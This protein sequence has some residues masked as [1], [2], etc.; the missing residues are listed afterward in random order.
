VA[1]NPVSMAFGS[2]PFTM[3][4]Y[5][6]ERLGYELQYSIIRNP[7]FTSDDNVKINEVYDRGFSLALRQKFYNPDRRFG[8]FYFAQELRFSTIDHFANVIDSLNMVNGSVIGASE[9][10]IEYSLLGGYRL[11]K[12]AGGTGITIDAFIGL[13]IG[14]R[15]FDREYP[16]SEEFDQV[17]DDIDTDK[18]SIP[19]RFGVNIGYMLE[20]R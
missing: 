19:F 18:L 5:F 8:M 10:R 7:F 2:I 1:T 13:G 11:V 20:A 9:K 17:F 16:A 15:D 6:Q 12:D 14:Y 4:Y 3:E